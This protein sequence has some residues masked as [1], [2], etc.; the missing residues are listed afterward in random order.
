M[1]IYKGKIPT[2]KRSL[3]KKVEYELNRVHTKNDGGYDIKEYKFDNETEQEKKTET[4][5]QELTFDFEELTERRKEVVRLLYKSIDRDE[6]TDWV[7]AS[8]FYRNA[9]DQQAICNLLKGRNEVRI[10]VNNEFIII[11][12]L[13]KINRYEFKVEV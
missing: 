13:E 11:R 7:V 3:T 12:K 2:K 6:E 8:R 5:Y 4:P 1:P 9:G 10:S